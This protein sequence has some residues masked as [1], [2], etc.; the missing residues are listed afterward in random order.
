[1]ICVTVL[2]TA[3]WTASSAALYSGEEG[4]KVGWLAAVEIKVLRAD[5]TTA[6]SKGGGPH[7]GRVQGLLNRL[8]GWAYSWEGVG[9]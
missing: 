4:P 5:A 8:G 9:L 6:C 1:M 7:S 3:E 2:L